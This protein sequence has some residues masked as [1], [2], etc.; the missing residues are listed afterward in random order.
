[1]TIIVTDLDD[2]IPYVQLPVPPGFKPPTIRELLKQEFD[3]VS[4]FWV[5]DGVPFEVWMDLDCAY[6][7]SV[8]P[9]REVH[10]FY[11]VTKGMR[12]SEREFRSL[13]KAMH[14]IAG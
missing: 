6:D 3:S 5:A 8:Y 13:V 7:W 11:P 9:V 12:I 14:C 4:S 2:E 1:M 10:P